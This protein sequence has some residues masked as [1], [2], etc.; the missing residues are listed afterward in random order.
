LKLRSVAQPVAR[1]GYVTNGL[2]YVIVGM[3]ALRAA[4]FRGSAEVGRAD[5]LLSIVTARYGAVLLAIVAAG[6]LGYA[7]AHILMALRSPEKD[8]KR[9]IVSW[10]NRGAHLVG[11]FAHLS[12]GLA[13]AR[14]VLTGLFDSGDTVSD[15][16]AWLLAAR[17]GRW[18][19]MGLGLA[20]AGG[21]AYAFH[22]AYTARFRAIFRDDIEEDVA[23]RGALMGRVG[24]TARGVI[25][26]IIGIFLFR[27]GWFYDAQEAGGLGHALAVLAEQPYYGAWY[28]GAVGIGLISYGLYGVFLGRYREMNF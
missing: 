23:N 14:L 15:W 18:L 28:V 20:I 22:K 11:G 3:L 16:T 8:T 9:G 17:W 5:A 21:S 1:I 24:Y 26:L 6:L 25:Y 7:L 27:A 12:L 13:A 19:V 10:L 4:L 2:T